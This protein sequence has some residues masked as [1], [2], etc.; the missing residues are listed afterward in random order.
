MEHTENHIIQKFIDGTLD[1]KTRLTITKKINRFKKSTEEKITENNPYKF[2]ADDAWNNLHKQIKKKDRMLE[3][4]F[5]KMG[6][7]GKIAAFIIV[8]IGFSISGYYIFRFDSNLKIKTENNIKTITLPDGSVVTL[9]TNSLISYP[10]IFGK[11]NRTVKFEGEA[12]FDIRKNPLKPFII[13]TNKAQIKVLGTSF[14]VNTGNK[15]TEVVVKTGKVEFRNIVKNKNK[16]ILTPGEKGISN[17]EK[18]YKINNTNLNY[19]SWK[20]RFFTYNNEK[21]KNIISDIN[22][23]YQVNIIFNNTEIGEIITGKTSFNNYNINTIIQIICETHHLHSKIDGKKII[24][25]Y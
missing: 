24:L 1:S 9:N 16:I 18:I 23:T 17:T 4:I 7:I 22:K 3:K 21:L 2:N 11:N 6:K 19:L 15:I 8:L 14:N 5:E 10:K 13:E 25:S 20:T 12:F